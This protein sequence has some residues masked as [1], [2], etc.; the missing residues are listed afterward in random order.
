MESSRSMDIDLGLT[1]HAQDQSQIIEDQIPGESTK[2]S[3]VG[4]PV[5]EGRMVW[6]KGERR[7]WDVE[8]LGIDNWFTWQRYHQEIKRYN[9]HGQWDMDKFSQ[10]LLRSQLEPTLVPLACRFIPMDTT[11]PFF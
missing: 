9:L 4:H 3:D 11:S 8:R 7:T 1:Q 10:N 5:L 2:G 6:I